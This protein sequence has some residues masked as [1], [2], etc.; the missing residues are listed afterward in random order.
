[1]PIFDVIRIDQTHLSKVIVARQ[2]LPEPEP[3]NGQKEIVEF[4][5]WKNHIRK[6]LKNSQKISTIIEHIL[7]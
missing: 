6:E 7:N 5:R 1:M 2:T 4:L 3:V